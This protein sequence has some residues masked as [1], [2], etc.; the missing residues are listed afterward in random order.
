MDR[1]E[2]YIADEMFFCGTACEV[3]PILSVD[4]I[5]VGDGKVGKTTREIQNAYLQITSG[6]NKNHPEWR[7]S[8]T[9]SSTV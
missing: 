9:I 3:T 2:L 8:C 4:R 1:T 6:K 7:R 5:A